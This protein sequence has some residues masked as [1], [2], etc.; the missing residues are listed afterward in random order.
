MPTDS[1]LLRRYAAQ[2]DQG[3]FAELVQRHVGV[4]YGS[5]LRRLAGNTHLAQ[6]VAQQVFL[7]LARKSAGLLSHPTVVG[8]LHRSTYYAA[9]TVLR[10][11]QRRRDLARQHNSMLEP[12]SSPPPAHWERLRPVLD[13][14]LNQLDERDRTVVLL[15]HF[16]ELSYGQIGTQLHLTE[17]A[18]RMRTDRAVEKLRA[19]LSR[20]GIT[21]SAAALELLLTNAAVAAPA[22]LAASF[23]AV[24]L[25]SSPA[26]PVSLFFM[27]KIIA[28]TVCALLAAGVTLTIASLTLP[29]VSGEE[30]ASLRKQNLLLRQAAAANASPA[31]P[32]AVA[33]RVSSVTI[34][35]AATT[36][37]LGE[38]L[39]RHRAADELDAAGKG[40]AG[41]SAAAGNHGQA[42]PQDAVQSFA[43]AANAGD[44][45]ALAKLIWF[46]PP[47][48]E[49]ANAIL[50]SMPDSVRAEYDTPEKFYAML[51]AADAIVAPAPPPEYLTAVTMV[52]LS[53]G[54]DAQQ[55]PGAS[56]PQLLRQYQQTLDGW[57][58]VLPIQGVDGLPNLLNN[59]QLIKDAANP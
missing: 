26:G 41:G 11:E 27:S 21:S 55:E 6:E 38:E 15:R 35:T 31:A 48:R 59:P 43:W 44:V 25:G 5:A 14:A 13:Q 3:A 33:G 32:A 45:D 50:A 1:E 47:A 58:Y 51:L 56:Q 20:L 46:D 10:A 22:G 40:G 8:W 57:K 36:R 23:T 16:E 52:E 53:P 4:V 39:A 49:R 7:D 42:T 37:A 24:A 28:P 34:R 18:A 2:R 17:N 54:R 9:S 12:S 30:L 19:H 29:G